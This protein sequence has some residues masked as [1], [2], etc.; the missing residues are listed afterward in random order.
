MADDVM[1]CR[2]DEDGEAEADARLLRAYE[3]LSVPGELSG[4]DVNAANF[5]SRAVMWLHWEHSATID[6]IACDQ[7]FGLSASTYRGSVDYPPTWPKR[8]ITV[9]CDTL[10]DGLAYIVEW[11]HSSPIKP[12]P[13]EAARAEQGGTDGSLQAE[14]VPEGGS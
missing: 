12:A 5:W 9:Q 3:I 7:W 4:R 6:W 8:N 14:A 10:E 2:C 1:V 11:F 13:R